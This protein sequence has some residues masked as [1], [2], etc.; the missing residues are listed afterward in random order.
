LNSNPGQFHFVFL[1]SLFHWENR[2]CLSH[3]VQVVGAV[4]RAAMRIVAGVG[5][6]MQRTRD[7]RTG[8]LLGGRAIERS[9]CAV[10]GLHRAHGD[11]EHG[12]L[13]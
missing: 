4:W 11:E 13:G 2:V 9:G 12:Y 10:C 5:D 6:Q 7:G 8:R 3:G 1:L